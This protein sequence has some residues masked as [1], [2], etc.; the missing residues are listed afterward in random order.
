MV[1]H[2][3]AHEVPLPMKHDTGVERLAKVLLTPPRFM[4]KGCQRR[5]RVQEA[6]RAAR[7]LSERLA[8]PPEGLGRRH[9]LQGFSE[10]PRPRDLADWRL[11]RVP[12]ARGPRGG[13][14]EYIFII[15]PLGSTT[16]VYG[17][18]QPQTI[19]K[20]GQTEKG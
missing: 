14:C 1:R 18:G 3:D 17:P 16:E 13:L 7:S 2:S 12:Y 6:L 10:L 8:T 11:D 20:A 9:A 19:T 15:L 5:T 4:R